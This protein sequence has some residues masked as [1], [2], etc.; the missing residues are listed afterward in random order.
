MDDYYDVV[1]EV[2]DGF[3]K[4]NKCVLRARCPYFASL[5]SKT[6]VESERKTVRLQNISRL[7]LSLVLQYI[8]TDTVC[9]PSVAKNYETTIHL[10][11][12][13]DYYLLPRLVEVTLLTV[14]VTGL[15]SVPWRAPEHAN[16]HAAHAL[17]LFLSRP[18]AAQTD[19]LLYR[20]SVA[21]KV[22]TP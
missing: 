6:F 21:L 3:I 14:T 16:R 15:Q 5:F 18:Q 12:H 1:L 10:L 7:Y 8:Y 17:R 19:R 20:L 9:L 13:A 2:N 4:A 22:F 11:I